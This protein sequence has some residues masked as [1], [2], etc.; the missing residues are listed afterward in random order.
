[1]FPHTNPTTTDAWKKLQSHF[2]EVQNISLRAYFNALPDRAKIFSRQFK[3]IYLDFSKNHLSNKTLKL[4]IE[5]AADVDLKGAMSAMQAGENINERENRSVLHIALRSKREEII[6]NGENVMP[7]IQNE[8]SQVKRITHSLHSGKWLGCTGKLIRHVVNIGIG[9]SYLGPL[10]VCHALK[11]YWQ[12]IT[13]HFLS[14]IDASNWE[15]IKEKIDP[16]ETIFII[17]SKTFLTDETMRNAKTVR[18]WFMDQLDYPDALS[19]HFIAVSTN[20]VEVQNFGIPKENILTFW[21][22]VGG[23]YSLWSSIGLSIACTIGYENFEKLLLGAE[24]MDTHFFTTDFEYNLPV[25]LALIAI[26]QVNFWGYSAKAILPY[27]HNMRDFPRFLQQLIMESNGKQVD[28][29]GHRLEYATCPIYFGELGTNGQHAFYQLLHQG[30]EVI[31]SDFIAIA[32]PAHTH[33]DHH[34]KLLSHCLA[35]SEA[36]MDGQVTNDPFKNFEGNRPSN[37]I[38]LKELSPKNLGS[39]IALYEHQVF[40]QGVIWNIYSFDQWGVELGKQLAK[41]IT[42]GESKN[43]NESTDELLR[44]IQSFKG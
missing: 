8:L 43:S 2:L 39:L 31:P 5:L 4:L 15:A 9:G 7:F 19:K 18:A 14:N 3:D 36:L 34:I 26:W 35:Q 22:W 28:R 40:V 25:L 21:N 44:K 11:P 12:N 10:M 30:T 16:E 27:D 24:E 29:N 20:K 13:P 42:Q 41:K 38:I 1:M 37:T 6:A 32:T 17:A 23:R 33:E